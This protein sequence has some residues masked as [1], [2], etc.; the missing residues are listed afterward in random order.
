MAIAPSVETTPA[1][2]TVPVE[3]PATRPTVAGSVVVLG[4][5]KS[6]G[7][8]D[9][10]TGQKVSDVLKSCQLST[11]A[12]KLTLVL[13]RRC[14]EGTS[15]EMI[16]LDQNLKLVDATRDYVLRDGD[17]LVVS[18]VPAVPAGLSRPMTAEMP[19]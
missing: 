15:R 1:I 9:L 10:T 12:T 11:P 16:D 13:N 14:P 18:V 4:D 6:P 3:S 17:E 2:Q 19:H 7:Q 8:R 5:I